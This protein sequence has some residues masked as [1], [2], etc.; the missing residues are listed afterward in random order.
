MIPGNE[1]TGVSPSSPG[2]HVQHRAGAACAARA[3]R[4][5]GKQTRTWGWAPAQEDPALL[6]LIE[7][8]RAGVAA[9]I[10]DLVRRYQTPLYNFTLRMSRNAEDAQ[11]A[12]QETFL[13]MFRSIG[14]F[15][16]ESRF[17]TWLFQIAAHACLKQRRRG[18]YDPRPGQELS[19]DELLQFRATGGFLELADPS[20]NAER[21]L[22][23]DELFAQ[24]E[25]A[26]K[27][28]PPDY[29]VVLL[30]RDAEGF[31]TEEAAAILKLSP[32]TMKSRLHRARLFIRRELMNYRRPEGD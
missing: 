22:L 32:P 15:R 14:E 13:A 5:G 19:L 25:A 2:A 11:D 3:H 6:A 8:A 27:M 12:L 17:T 18:A 29:R 31:S 21:A 24:V 4:A 26:I 23:R 7:A 16:G 10:E 9:A 20:E 1:T 30:L 28:L